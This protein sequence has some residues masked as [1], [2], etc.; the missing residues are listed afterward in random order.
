MLVNEKGQRVLDT[1][2][3]PQH[4]ELNL[5]AGLRQT[6]NAIAEKKA[7]PIDKVRQ[8]VLQLI[9][10]KKV[11]GYHLPQKLADF[12]ILYS[13]ASLKQSLSPEKEKPKE[14]VKEDLPNPLPKQEK[15]EPKPKPVSMIE[16]AY[17]CAKIFNTSV[18]GQ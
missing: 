8:R 12:G 13:V 18:S 15:Q 2:I 4:P 16:E 9:K 1:M 3:K 6:L 10:G 5:K 17:D 11:V 7:E 14:D